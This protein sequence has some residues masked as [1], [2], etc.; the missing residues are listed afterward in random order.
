MSLGEAG[1]EAWLV[2][3]LLAEK[4][5]AGFTPRLNSL[6]LGTQNLQGFPAPC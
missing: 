2:V 1:V 5:S 4:H 3:M 6:F